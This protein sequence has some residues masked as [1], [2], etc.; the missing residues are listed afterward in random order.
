[1]PAT[2][3]ISIQSMAGFVIVGSGFS[4]DTRRVPGANDWCRHMRINSFEDKIE[5]KI[6]SRGTLY[7]AGGAIDELWREPGGNYCA[8]VDGTEPYEV[9]V[10]VDEDGEIGAH[11]CDCPYDWGEFCKHEVAVMLAIRDARANQSELPGRRGKKRRGLKAFLGRYKK[12]ELIELVCAIS[13]EYDL[14]EQIE[15]YFEEGGRDEQ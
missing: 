14:R 15:Q 10:F 7:F 3:S 11:S 9:M 1:M 13:R 12:E 4:R 5:K 2:G 8:V 6:L